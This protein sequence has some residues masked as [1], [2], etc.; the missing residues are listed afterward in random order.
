MNTVVLIGEVLIGLCVLYL[1]F[2]NAFIKRKA[3]NLADKQDI[4]DITREIELVKSTFT[5]ENEKLKSRLQVIQNNQIQHLTNARTSVLDF[6]EDWS[7]WLNNS[8]NATKIN[9]YTKFNYHTLKSQINLIDESYAKASLRCDR[10]ELLIDDGRIVVGA[11]SLVRETLKYQEWVVLLLVSL[12]SL[13]DNQKYFYDKF[14]KLAENPTANAHELKRIAD[15]DIKLN[16][17][18]KT[19]V[20]DYY[21]NSIEK[22]KPVL[23]KKSKFINEVKRYFN[24]LGE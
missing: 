16:E 21:D 10:L 22:M 9:G 19:C 2:T 7:V 11:Y 13:F 23:D 17:R 24:E 8:L 14:V 20:N 3:N 12:E 1:A 15:E 18:I 6:F 5:A 4:A